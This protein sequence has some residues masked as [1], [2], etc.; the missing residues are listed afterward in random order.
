MLRSVACERTGRQAILQTRAIPLLV[1]LLSAPQEGP[2]PRVCARAI[3]TLHN[4]TCDHQAIGQLRA[5]SDALRL[6]AV[7]LQSPHDIRLRASAAG[8][9]QNIALDEECRRELQGLAVVEHLSALA[10]GTDVDAQA[11]A[12]GALWNMSGASKSSDRF[13]SI[14]A[15]CLVAGALL[16]DSQ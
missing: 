12:I 2:I 15:D 3:A 16:D 10:L 1:P 5:C 7:L 8:V 4:L 6:I 9:V 11:H 14:L 13:K